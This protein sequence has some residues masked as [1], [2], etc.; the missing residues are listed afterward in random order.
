MPTFLG[1]YMEQAPDELS[2]EHNWNLCSHIKKAILMSHKSWLLIYNLYIPVVKVLLINYK[3]SEVRFY[4]IPFEWTELFVVCTAQR[5]FE[6]LIWKVCRLYKILWI[7]RF[8]WAISRSWR[9]VT[10]PIIWW[11]IPRASRSLNE[12]L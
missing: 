10:A 9:Y 1:L 2:N 8:R 4:M 5:K 12:F 6:I 11:K 7:L 3:L